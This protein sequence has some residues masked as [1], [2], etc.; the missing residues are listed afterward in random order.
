MHI[1]RVGVV[2]LGLCHI[3]RVRYNRV[4]GVRCKKLYN[5]YAPILNI[6]FLQCTRA[7]PTSQ[8]DRLSDSSHPIILIRDDIIPFNPH[9]YWASGKLSMHACNCVNTNLQIANSLQHLPKLVK[10][11]LHMVE[12]SVWYSRRNIVNTK[13]FHNYSSYIV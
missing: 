11:V 3:L 13:C 10:D 1:L 8:T 2:L 9:S 12:N 7:I 4:L 5:N 6:V